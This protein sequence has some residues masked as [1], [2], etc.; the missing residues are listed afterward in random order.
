M[1]SFYRAMRKKHNVLMQGDQPL[2]G[3]WNY[4]SDNRKKL[5]KDHKPT[6]PLVFNNEV[7][8][9]HEEINS[10]DIKTIG[11]IE[12]KNFVW[13]INR[14]QSLELLDFLQWNVYHYSEVTKMRCLPTNGRCIIRGFLFR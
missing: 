8:A 3:Q 7:S 4:D 1:E 13:P 2:T 12:T 5:P 11:T 10:T 6:A 14:T 9:I